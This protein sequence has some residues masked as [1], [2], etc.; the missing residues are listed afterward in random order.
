MNR[1]QAQLILLAYR[2]GEAVPEESDLGQALALA[3]AD[4]SLAEWLEQEM[5]MDNR[6]RARAREVS[7]P[8]G[9]RE[10]ILAESR[11]VRIAWWQR[12]GLLAAAAGLLV[13]VGSAGWWLSSGLKPVSGGPSKVATRPASGTFEDFRSEMVRF[14]STG[15]YR[16]DVSTDRLAEVRKYLA[17]RGTAVDAKIPRTLERLDTYGCQVL[18]WNGETVTLI[19]FQASEIQIAHLVIIDAR[20]LRNPPTGPEPMVA[21]VGTW[22]AAGWRDGDKVL[23]VCSPA[24][25]AELKRY[26]GG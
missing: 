26:L 8:A 18:D 24:G 4:P 22:T 5:D 3:A 6:I 13:L 10:R 21:G 1:E 14:V 15:A 20:A 17:S 7:P 23:I 16:L 12:P 9:L 25:G 2:R 11:I 19:C